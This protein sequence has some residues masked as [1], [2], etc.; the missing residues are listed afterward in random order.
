MLDSY[1]A[2]SCLGY[3][4]TGGHVAACVVKVLFPPS[5]QHGLCCSYLTAGQAKTLDKSKDL[6]I[7]SLVS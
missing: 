3:L 5:A 7:C 6:G 1:V 4:L 2:R